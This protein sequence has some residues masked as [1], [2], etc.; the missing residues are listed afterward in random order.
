MRIYIL[1]QNAPVYLSQFLDDF[2]TQINE[3]HS[4]EGIVFSSPYFSKNIYKEII[5]R[6]YLYGLINFIRM[7]FLI[8]KNKIQS[9]FF[10][11]RINKKCMSSSNIIRKYKLLEHKEND[12]NGSQF[13]NF[14]KNKNIDLIISIAS[15]IIFKESLLKAPKLGCINYHT[16]YLPKYRGR[17]PLF[18][19]MLNN[20]SYFGISIHYMDKKLDNGP[21]IIQT[22]VPILRS[23]SLHDLYIKSINIGPLLLS[24]ALVKLSSENGCSINNDFKLS[25]QYSFP[26]YSD[27]EKFR[28]LNKNIF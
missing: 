28:S 10:H 15:P 21:I 13:I 2:L 1:T 9:Y 8:I 12:L 23:D 17:Q 25:T 18:W 5:Q 20:E 22:K 4:I 26:K 16:G 14:L 7:S 19:A 6:F 27:A 24:K 11:F 3:K